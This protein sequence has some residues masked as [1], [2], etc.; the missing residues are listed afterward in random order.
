[1]LVVALVVVLNPLRLGVILLVISR[2]RPIHNLLAFWAGC[3][4]VSVAFL[5]FPL[6]VLHVTPTF[7]SFTKDLASP[8]TATGST[9]RHIQIGMGVFALSVAVL[10]AVRLWAGQRARVPAPGRISSTP[11]LD[12]NTPTAIS[13]L[14]GRPANGGGQQCAQNAPRA[15]ASAIRRLL[16]RAHNAWEN[17]SLWVPSVIGFI[18]G[19]APDTLLFV[20]AIIVASG[21]AIGTQLIAAIAFIF[22]SL[23]VVEAIPACYLVAPAKTQAVVQ[24]LHDWA[25]SHRRQVLTAIFAVVGAWLIAHGMGSV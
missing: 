9:V 14:E 4:M 20:L 3:L 13:W 10:M 7:A 6:M 23:A 16:D 17:G 19:P 8:R 2:P 1:V 11:M 25:E 5:L 21:A 22:A 18:L 12:S 15:G 24:L